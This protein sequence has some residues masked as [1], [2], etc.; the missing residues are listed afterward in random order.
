MDIVNL[1]VYTN[2]KSNKPKAGAYVYLLEFVGN[3]KKL[4]PEPITLYNIEN[5]EESARAAELEAIKK[6]LQRLKKPCEIR[7]FGTVPNLMATFQNEW[8]KLWH[9]SGWLNSKGEP[10]QNADEWQ[11]IYELLSAHKITQTSTQR[12]S[13]SSWF[14]NQIEGKISDIKENR[15][16]VINTIYTAKEQIEKALE[17]VDNTDFFESD[18]F[19][20][21]VTAMADLLFSKIKNPQMG[22]HSGFVK[23]ENETNAIN[24]KCSE[25]TEIKI[26]SENNMNTDN[27]D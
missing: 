13:Y 5:I 26:T 24:T 8:F 15:I 12:H 11:E 9:D 3:E 10:I 6:A 20:N 2:I 7:L 1:Y 17:S 14:E 16:N 27:Q 21:A 4:F 25:N 22:Y 19:T 18:D 23:I